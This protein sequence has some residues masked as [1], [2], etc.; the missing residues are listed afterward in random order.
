MNED[1]SGAVLGHTGE[2]KGPSDIYADTTQFHGRH[3][4]GANFAFADGHVAWLS[5]TIR[6]AT[7]AALSTRA[8]GEVISNEF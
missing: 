4:R 2:G 6:Y 3:S 1:G 7:Y 5:N 8:L